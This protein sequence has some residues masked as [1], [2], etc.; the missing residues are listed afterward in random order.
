MSLQIPT[1]LSGIC[2]VASVISSLSDAP[3]P[4]GVA[5]VARERDLQPVVPVL[6]GALVLPI[7]KQF[8]ILHTVD[9][10]KEDIKTLKSYGLVVQYNLKVEGNMPLAALKF[11]YLTLNLNCKNDRCY[12]DSQD[13][14]NCNIICVI[15]VIE[16]FDKY[17]E[18]LECTNV[19]TEFPPRQHLKG[20]FD[21]LL[22]LQATES[23][24]KCMSFLTF[25]TNYI[26]SKKKH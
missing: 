14:T 9:L 25:I 5:N 20:D 23:P 22:M 19:I 21:A 6:S 13:T 11:D 18:N 8:I 12:L 15:S 7:Q 2:N 24:S 17:I 10:K 26:A 1:L 3:A 16:Q 4:L